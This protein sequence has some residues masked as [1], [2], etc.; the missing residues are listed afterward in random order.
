[1]GAMFTKQQTQIIGEIARLVRASASSHPHVN[2]AVWQRLADLVTELQ[3]SSPSAPPSDALDAERLRATIQHVDASVAYLDPEFNFV[4]ANPT[5]VAGCGHTLDELLGR[6]HFDLFPNA[7]NQAIFERVRDTGEPAIFAAKPFVYAD[8]PE[9]GV[10]YWNW[11]L[12]PDHDADGRLRGL[13]FSLQDVTAQ[14]R[15]RAAT[16]RYLER[17]NRLIDVSKQ[18]MAATTSHELMQRVVDAACA[19]TGARIGAGGYGL[20]DGRC[21][22]T[23]TA[24]ADDHSPSPVDDVFALGR[25]GEHVALMTDAVSLRLSEA[26]V[27]LHPIWGR[28]VKGGHPLRGLLS[29][30]LTDVTGQAVG[31]IVL[32]DKAEGALDAEDEALLVHLATIASLGL[33]HIAQRAEAEHH[34]NEMAATFAA[35]ADAVVVLDAQGN[36]TWANPA[37]TALFGRDVVRTDRTDL[38][39]RLD[40]R[41]AEGRP[42]PFSQLPSSRLLRGELISKER[43]AFTNSD[44][45]R[46]VAI[47]SAT[48]LWI[49]GEPV[50]GVA[51]WHDMTEREALLDRLSLEQTRLQTIIDNVPQG[52]IVADAAANTIMINPSVRALSRHPED[53]TI[54]AEPTLYG[55]D[56]TVCRWE[57]RPLTRSALYGEMLHDVEMTLRWPDGAQRHLLVNSVPIRDAASRLTGGVAAIQDISE[58]K[59][60]ELSLR[61]YADEQAALYAVSSAIASWTDPDRLLST[62]LEVVLPILD[63]E[64]GWVLLPGATPEDPPRVGASRGL[65]AEFIAAT[66]AEPLADCVACAA[67]LRDVD[68]DLEPQYA[69]NC[70]R[71]S[72]EVLA[73]SGLHSHVVIPL[74]TSERVLGILN[75][76]WRE[77][78]AYGP[79][80]RALADAIGR[81][82]GLALYNAQLFQEARQV[83]RLRALGELDQELATTL[84]SAQVHAVGLRHMMSVL[85]ASEGALLTVPSC[86]GDT[87][88]EVLAADT[89]AWSP[90]RAERDA[91]A[92]ARTLIARARRARD[93]FLISGTEAAAI[94]P[95][96]GA[97]QWGATALATPVQGSDGALAV[98]LT[99]HESSRPFGDEDLRVARA[100]ALRLAQA[101]EN[102]RLYEAVRQ[103]RQQVR[104]LAARLSQAEE[105]ERQRIARELHDRVGQDLTALSFNLSI[106]GTLLPRDTE[107]SIMARLRDSMRLVEQTTKDIRNIMAELRPLVLDDYGLV[108]G[109]QWYATEF[110]RRMGIRTCVEGQEPDPRLES[111]I[112]TALFRVAQEALTNVVKHAQASH[113]TISVATH[114]DR[115]RLVVADD[116][117]GFDPSAIRGP[118]GD[119][120]WGLFS[121]A[122]RIEAVGGHCIVD[123]APNCGTRIVAEVNR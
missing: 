37:A 19:L 86:D 110:G 21:Q 96:G 38:A 39:R 16:Q 41:D 79:A 113:V 95:C 99:G 75:V 118:K 20:C 62:V 7:E 12:V 108:A 42:I 40:T 93:P 61:R 60:A 116:G 104:I 65:S 31:L 105:A 91:A 25:G 11:T 50:G 6:N 64:V 27:Q 1:M 8:Q 51:T 49:E 58:R 68:V 122:E 107:D 115:V 52:I 81:Q 69:E 80:E 28:L 77:P 111:S 76:G 15:G 87:P 112:E 55:P 14:E 47:V 63:A 88:T 32:T 90:W 120:G 35:L 121:M 48:P 26:E 67:L 94:A 83:D 74:K 73:A 59:S 2:D 34:A 89:G 66:E 54:T 85:R 10:T 22:L 100:V 98:I 114:K 109:L 45:E 17:M 57:D 4:Y 119:S 29:A 24:H 3:R 30:R 46:R 53:E 106:V 9:R 56:G 117:V 97:A 36:I 84:E 78:H 71:L 103:Q 18:V 82:V 72:R 102:A 13:I 43:V 123:S 70:P 23:V 44:G 101:G 5:Y 33:Q 92:S